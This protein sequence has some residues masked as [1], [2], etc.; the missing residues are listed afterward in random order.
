MVIY[1]LAID[2]G[3][4]LMGYGLIATPLRGAST[5]VAAGTLEAERKRD[6]VGARLAEIH[7]SL[8]GLLREWKQAGIVP[9]RFAMEGGY[10][11]KQSDLV[12]AYA[13]GIAVA[14]V[15]EVFGLEAAMVTPSH[16]KLVVAGHGRA[17]KDAVAAAV[18]ATLGLRSTPEPD[19]ADALA[20]ALTAAEDAA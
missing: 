10:A 6:K 17:D 20:I 11:H 14:A 7:R 13:R 19:A 12:V 15:S 4:I 16:V 1:T 9:S 3:T 18:K 8:V 5:Y 2:P